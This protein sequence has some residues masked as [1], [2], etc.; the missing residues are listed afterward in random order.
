MGSNGYRSSFSAALAALAAAVSPSRAGTTS[1]AGAAPL[2]GAPAP[3]AAEAHPLSRRALRQSLRACTAEGLFAEVV[4][5]CAGGAVLTGWALHVKASPLL[6]GLVVAL[7]QLAQLFQIPAA[8]TTALA[9]HRR[10]CVVLVGASRQVLLPLAVLPFLPLAPDAQQAVLVA[11]AALSAVLG[12]LGNNAWV[13]WMG[14]LVPR[15]IRGRY[16]GRRTSLC[17]LGGAIASAGAGAL[18]DLARGRGLEGAALGGLQLVACASGLVTVL[19]MLRQHD[20][21]PHAHR[22]PLRLTDAALPFRDPDA[23]GLLAYQLAWNGAVGVAGSFFSLFMLTSLG[24]GFTLVALHGTAV[25]GIRMLA[26]PVWGRLID[27]VGARPVLII[28]S[29][30][31]AF[32]PFLWLVPTRTAWLAPLVADAI[33]AGALWSGHTL[34]AFA[35]PLAATPRKGRPFYLAGISATSGVAFAAATALAGL[36]LRAMPDEVIVGG[37][38]LVDI[39]LLFAA[40]GVLRFVAAFTALGIREPASRGVGALWPALASMLAPRP[41]RGVSDRAEAARPRRAAGGSR[42]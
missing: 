30:G 40:S 9:G 21:C 18:L 35:L 42:R 26:A 31:I 24:M 22:A 14:E 27:R 38:R 10:A 1:P 13:A 7:P 4:T 5:A 11:V 12:V 36:A 17:M 32:I 37:H 6:T 3:G 20:P 15:R 33:L 8:W 29:F 41:S 39:Q 28:C 34:A 23:R 2:A 16:F 25:A 19:L